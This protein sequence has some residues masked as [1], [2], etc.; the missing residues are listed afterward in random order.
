VEHPVINLSPTGHYLL[1]SVLFLGPMNLGQAIHTCSFHGS[2]VDWDGRMVI[3][4]IHLGIHSAIFSS[5]NRGG[6]SRA[7]GWDYMRTA[8]TLLWD[9]SPTK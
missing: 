7:S 8:G 4:I 3:I 2:I 6:T 5:C 9:G 1:A